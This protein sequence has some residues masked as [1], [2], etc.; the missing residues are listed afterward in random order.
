LKILIYRYGPLI[1]VTG[2]LPLPLAEPF[3]L[4]I[5]GIPAKKGT[6]SGPSLYTNI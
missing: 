4:E 6:N 2:G 1:K 3:V 5:F